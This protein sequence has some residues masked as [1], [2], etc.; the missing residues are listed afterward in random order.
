MKKKVSVSIDEDLLS[1]AY[2][3]VENKRFASLSHAV[4]YALNELRKSSQRK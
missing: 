1:W 3:Q 4:D 2:Q